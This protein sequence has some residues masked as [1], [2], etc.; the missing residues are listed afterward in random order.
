MAV[1]AGLTQH[2]TA[3]VKTLP[4]QTTFADIEA[5][6]PGGCVSGGGPDSAVYQISTDGGNY[7]WIYFDRRTATTTIAG[8]EGEPE[9]LPGELEAVMAVWVD[10]GDDGKVDHDKIISPAS[11]DGQ[12]PHEALDRIF[13]SDDD[14]DDVSGDERDA[15]KDAVDAARDAA[16]AAADAVAASTDDSDDPGEAVDAA[17]SAED[18]E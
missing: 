12:K 14:G 7:I 18:D 1:C 6:F 13:P 16:S 9:T 10:G 3:A 11:F 5:K 8:V 4:A 15:V 2:P 17:A